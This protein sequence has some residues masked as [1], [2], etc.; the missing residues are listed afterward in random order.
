MSYYRPEAQPPRR[1]RFSGL[2]LR[3]VMAAGIMLFAVISYFAQS[4]INPVTGENQRISLSPEQ[5][6]A[7]GMQALPVMVRQHGG[8]SNK[9]ADVRFV[10]S[11]GARL[12]NAL[13][14]KLMQEG[15]RQPY[16]F[17][18][19]LLA[20][21]NTVNAFAL[22]GGQ[23]FITEALLDQMTAEGQ[24]AGVLGHEIGH[25]LERHSAERMSKGGFYSQI[26]GAVGVAGGDRGSMQVASIV[27]DLMNKQFS[28]S[29]EYESDK[30][31]LELMIRAGYHPHR[32]LEVMDILQRTGGG[33][34]PSFLSTHPAPADRKDDIE[35]LLAQW[36]P[37]G[38]PRG[39]K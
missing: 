14:I 32:M 2:Q 25:V 29:H 1:R 34:G 30:W 16:S 13:E 22:P 31:G 8:I 37:N 9:S 10:K 19:H 26:A 36:Y 23:V 5:E 11:V 6:T 38:L 17:D 18:F 24:L 21:P 35:K 3:L 39:L 15:K 28:R 7:M 12:M 27:S 33:S 20:D 4:E